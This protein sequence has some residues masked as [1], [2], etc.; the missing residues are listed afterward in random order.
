MTAAVTRYGRP[1]GWKPIDVSYRSV[2]KADG[3]Y[4]LTNAGRLRQQRGNVVY[5]WLRCS[6]RDDLGDKYTRTVASHTPM[7]A[8]GHLES[9][10]DSALPHPDPS[11]ERQQFKYLRI[12]RRRP[13][14]AGYGYVDGRRW[15][16]ATDADSERPVRFL[17]ADD[18]TTGV[19]FDDAQ[20]NRTVIKTT[21][22]TFCNPAERRICITGTQQERGHHQSGRADHARCGTSRSMQTQGRFLR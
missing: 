1:M 12:G 21:Y 19:A 16:I 18:P 2:G 5:V 9:I 17:D 20:T 6:R 7:T 15:R 13:A 22:W 4:G 11:G 8:P 3:S 14:G 10:V